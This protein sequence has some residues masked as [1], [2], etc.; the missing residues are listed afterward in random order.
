[1]I[2]SKAKQKHRIEV[3]NSFFFFLV[4][5]LSDIIILRCNDDDYDDCVA[6]QHS[7]SLLVFVM[8]FELASQTVIVVKKKERI[9]I[10]KPKQT[11]ERLEPKKKKKKNQ[12]EWKYLFLLSVWQRRLVHFFFLLSKTLTC[13]R[14]FVDANETNEIYP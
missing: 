7:T 14:L 13:S 8:K 11:R 6:S 5:S 12:T 4:F 10:W 2:P 9:R 1:M 3:Q